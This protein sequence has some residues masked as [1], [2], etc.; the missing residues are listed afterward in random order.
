MNAHDVNVPDPPSIF[1]APP[2]CLK[3]RTEKEKENRFKRERRQIDKL[4]QKKFNLENVEIKKESTKL[5]NSVLQTKAFN[6]ICE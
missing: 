1:T 6:L 5:V 2:C 4:Y 3:N